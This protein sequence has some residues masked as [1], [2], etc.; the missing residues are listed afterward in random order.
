MLISIAALNPKFTLPILSSER[1][2]ERGHVEEIVHAE[3][4]YLKSFITRNN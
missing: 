2:R 1:E 4:N 3:S